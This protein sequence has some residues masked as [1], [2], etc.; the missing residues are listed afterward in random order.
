MITGSKFAIMLQSRKLT[1][2]L[3]LF[4]LNDPGRRK[5]STFFKD[6]KLRWKN[7]KKNYYQGPSVA[8][9]Q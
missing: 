7:K 8:E 3:Q 1:P 5:S 2:I 9:C 6:E 4:G